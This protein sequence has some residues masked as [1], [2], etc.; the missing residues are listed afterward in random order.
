M[1]AVV[2]VARKIAGY[3]ANYHLQIFINAHLL[4][5]K[6]WEKQDGGRRLCTLLQFKD[7]NQ[8]GWISGGI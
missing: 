6:L 2:Q 5:L 7:R 4:H 8:E 3:R 1:M